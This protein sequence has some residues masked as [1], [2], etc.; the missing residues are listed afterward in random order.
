MTGAALAGSA[1]R[2]ELGALQFIVGLLLALRLAGYLWLQPIPDEAYYWLWSRHPDLS[3]F[4]HPGLNAWIIALLDLVLGHG[5]HVL[6]L[7][8]L[9]TLGGTIAIFHAW[10]RRFAGPDWEEMFWRGLAI[11][12]AAP[13]FGVAMSIA[14]SDHLL[15]FFALLS[16][17]CFICYLHEVR[18]GRAGKLRHLYAGAVAL[19][20]AGLSKYNAVFLGLA[21]VIYIL[22]SRPLR[23]LLA[24]PHLWA[25]GALAVAMQA[26]TLIWNFEHGLSSFQFHLIDRHG[27]GSFSRLNPRRLLEFVLS[28]MAVTSPFMAWAMVKY[29]LR[30]QGE[31]AARTVWQLGAL[32]FW[33][34]SVTFLVISLTDRVQWWWNVLG[35]VLIV[36]MLGLAMRRK[37]LLYG[38]LI[39]G[40]LAS[41]LLF[42]TMALFP[43]LVLFGN[44][45]PAYSRVYGWERVADAVRT[46]EIRLQ[47][48]FVAA[49]DWDTTSLVGYYTN[50]VEV[51][52]LGPRIG[53]FRYWHDEAGLSGR[54]AVLVL[55]DRDRLEEAARQFERLTEVDKVVTGGLGWSFN[56]YRIYF[57]EGYRPLA[58]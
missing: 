55:Y 51:M 45:D 30:P 44:P 19:G 29:A 39:F 25:A 41:L 32:L 8:S 43:T 21:V 2:R 56:T 57:A 5:I 13:T 12:L 1:A 52:P 48:D 47:P 15:V 31:G 24:N 22:A 14:T 16:G 58:R 53:Q 18:E 35:Y 37:L 34:S 42:S 27:A 20:F 7:P 3:Y 54:N 50:N 38:H 46:A 40:S 6:R 11:Y 26:P 9:L 10:A 28:S 4:D 23:K 17:Y 49:V 33:V 36:P